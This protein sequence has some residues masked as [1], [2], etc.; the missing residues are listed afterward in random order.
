MAFP[1]NKQ[2]GVAIGQGADQYRG[3]PHNHRRALEAEPVW[4]LAPLFFLNSLEAKCN[5]LPGSDGVRNVWTNG[6]DDR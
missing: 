6:G 3:L 1:C 2:R 4:R 5:G